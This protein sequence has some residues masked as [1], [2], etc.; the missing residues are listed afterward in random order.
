MTRD[1]NV[2]ALLGGLGNQLFQVAF[3]GW[4]E[5]Q[6][7]RRTQYDVSFHRNLALDV[8]AIPDVGAAV[9]NRLLR[10]TRRLPTPD[11]RLA[12]VG[13]RARA[14]LGPRRV[15]RD[16]TAQGP[17]PSDRLL[18]GWWFGYWQRL[19]YADALL[20]DLVAGLGG[21]RHL[22][23]PVVG[24]HMRRGDMLS[25]PSAVPA[26]WP[27]EALTKLRAELGGDAE[28]PVRVWS[29]DPDWCCAELDLG[30]A[31]EVA[32]K[33]PAVEDLAAL[34]ACRAL[35][36]SRSTF[37][38]W[39]ARIAAGRGS[40]VVYPAPWRSGAPDETI[41]PPSWIPLAVDAALSPIESAMP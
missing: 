22:P 6:T 13:Q 27:A 26:S 33:G 29:D 38:W 14:I 35:V 9:R 12:G 36:V 2:V 40:A 34:S 19:T 7:G 5:Q 24:V 18:A 21:E 30:T 39:A 11:G 25:T 23:S 4:L 32:P 1:R 28:L 17:E 3:G 20:P 31:F 16:Y 8:F 15:V 41:V 37:S 10:G